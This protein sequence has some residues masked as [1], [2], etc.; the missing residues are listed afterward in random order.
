[1]NI[2]TK[3]SKT[4]KKL[5]A[6][7]KN[8]SDIIFLSDVRLNSTKQNYAIHDLEKKCSLKGYDLF[9]NS[10]GSSRGVGILISKKLV[11][12]V[13]DTLSDFDDNYLI[14]CTTIGD[15][16]IN[17]VSI[18]GPNDNNCD[19]FDNLEQDLRVLDGSPLIVGG[20]WN[21]T[22]DSS[23]VNSNIDVLNMVNIPSRVRSEK[24]KRLSILFNLTDPYRAL[25]PDKFEYTFVPNI[26]QHINRSRLDFFLVTKSLLND[27]KNCT[28]EPS[29]S[30]SLFDHKMVTLNFKKDIKKNKQKINDTILFNEDLGTYVKC[31]VIDCYINHSSITQN[32][33]LERKTELMAKIGRIFKLISDT[34][35]LKI[36]LAMDGNVQWPLHGATIEQNLQNIENLID[37]LP[38]IEFFENLTLECGRDIFFE[39]LIMTIKNSALSFQS[40]HYKLLNIKKTK[41]KKQLL[42]L[43]RNYSENSHE[44]KMGE[45]ELSHILD[46]ELKK[47]LSLVKNFERLNDEKITP[48]FL[49]LAKKPGHSKTLE[50]IKDGGG[51]E[52]ANKMERSTYITDFYKELYKKEPVNNGAG[53]SIE[54]YLGDCCNHPV[55][56]NSKLT[57]DEKQELDRPFSIDELDNSLKLSKVNTAPGI[58]GIS[59]R[60][61]KKFWNLFR[62]PLFDYCIACF[63][64]GN[65]TDIF[66]RAKIRLI[67]KKG[68][69]SQIK[70]WRPISL[71]NCFYKIL[72][73]AIAQRIKKY[74]DKICSVGQ[75]GYSSKHQC[76]EVL[77]SL[78][79]EIAETKFHQKRGALL[80]LDIRKAFDTISHDY[81]NKVYK[82]FNFG[83]YIISWL[84]LIGTNRQACI[85]M[86]D[87]SLTEFFNLERGNAQGDTIS[88]YLFNIGYQ[89]LLFKIEFS[90]QITGISELP[91]VPP[92]LLPLPVG[93]STHLRKIHAFADDG[94]CLV[95]F[96]LNNLSVL[97]DFL[98]QFGELSGLVANVEKTTLM[99]VGRVEPVSRDI[100]DL[101]FEL[102]DSTT[103]LGLELN[104]NGTFTNSLEKIRGK[105]R[106]QIVK[107]SRFNLSLPGR[108]SIAKCMMYSQLNYLGC[109]LDIDEIFLTEIGQIIENFVL[110]KQ[111][112]AKKRLYLKTEEG[113]LGLFDIKIFLEAQKCSWIKRA[114][115]LD[116]KWKQKIYCKSYGNIF[117]IRSHNFN[118]ITEPTLFGIVNAFE[119]FSLAYTRHNE[120]FL[121]SYVFENSALPINLRQRN[122]LE[123]NTL[124]PG[125]Y[126]RNKI[127][128]QNF[129]VKDFLDNNLRTLSIHQFR[130]RTNAEV[131]QNDYETFK[132]IV[133]NAKLKYTKQE[134]SEKKTLSIEEFM[135][136]KV[137]GSRRFRKI[138]VGVQKAYIPHNMVKFAESTETIINYEDSKYL[139]KFWSNSFLSNCTRTFLFKVHNNTAGYNVT[140]AHFI[141]GHDEN[142]TFCNEVRNPDPERE[143]PLHLFYGCT[144]S[145]RICNAVFSHY[146]G[147]NVTVSR[148]EFFVKFS[149]YTQT[150]NE[151]L[152]YISVHLK[153]FLWDC[154][155]R[156][157]LPNFLLAI[158][159]INS[160][161]KCNKT[162]NQKF[163]YK[164]NSSGFNFEEQDF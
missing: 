127:Q 7:T 101:G 72:S 128:Y 15:H 66:R 148:Q 64:K 61:I 4:E 36:E 29:I 50:T 134:L 44:I 53:L 125:T 17:L 115:D 113:G 135:S 118:K 86:E 122:R 42:D 59:N 105:V 146:L 57:E 145:E 77:I 150:K 26:A 131:T 119:K 88:P 154:K 120:N 12:T 76:Q 55:V 37:G 45:L 18:Y 16:K 80:S 85:I 137:K 11:Y 111:K 24:I 156:K 40:L 97:K 9:F 56:I 143:T 69:C 152:D 5:I 65:L 103:V 8:K 52:L 51:G 133:S 109:F 126:T 124:D 60:F 19:F 33:S 28:I 157:G 142:C 164:V 73:R 30:C 121:S 75:K 1:M 136:K 47:E 123:V 99:Q 21:A 22:W 74:M 14:L 158:K 92:D 62:K 3:N 155:V 98:G 68:D 49:N 25:N 153:K 41:I 160:E 2:S 108:I 96:T 83:D 130:L 70:N 48:Y 71:L 10:K 116:E 67:P 107:W 46:D 163:A 79:D 6:I 161:I 91:T 159:Y 132:K 84:K 23:P 87:E 114:Y 54:E 31:H 100:L 138:F 94:S 63:Q 32:F 34:Q 117:N 27:C 78:I 89:I 39:V 13:S 104:N 82:F 90:L 102:V 162:I 139:N 106:S 151:I 147:E 93:V 43:K 81:L 110:G 35:N 129:K 141:R 112:I 20:D 149:K 38:E 95:E 58:D 144:V 140:V